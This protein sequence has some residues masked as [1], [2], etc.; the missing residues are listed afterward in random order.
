MQLDNHLPA[1]TTLTLRKHEEHGECNWS[2]QDEIEF[3]MFVISFLHFDNSSSTHVHVLGFLEARNFDWRCK[4]CGI[5]AL[6]KR[7]WKV[8]GECRWSSQDAV[9]FDVFVSILHCYN[10]SSTH[11]HVIRLLQ[12]RGFGGASIDVQEL[13]SHL[14][15]LR[16]PA[17]YA[18]PWHTYIKI[19]TW[20]RR[21]TR[22]AASRMMSGRQPWRLRSS[23]RACS[24]K[25]LKL[26]RA[27]G[28]STTTL[29]F[30]VTKE[31]LLPSVQSHR[32]VRE[33]SQ[34][35]WGAL[36]RPWASNR[37]REWC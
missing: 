24:T 32:T 34:E 17:P 16:L 9:E 28:F 23:Q 6:I 1:R 37:V 35:G 33:H 7:A 5:D 21:W 29:R 10:S 18:P 26:T 11:V 4:H 8:H 25:S 19:R 14:D 2:S 15:Y 27:K 13:I 22:V 12:A 3:D 20:K 31:A 30:R 36:T